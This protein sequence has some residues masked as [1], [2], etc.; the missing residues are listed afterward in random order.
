MHL[1]GYRDEEPLESTGLMIRS[2]EGVSM[3]RSQKAENI[4]RE[5]ER[6]TPYMYE[7]LYGNF[8]RNFMASDRS[9]WT[10][11]LSGYL[12][13]RNQDWSEIGGEIADILWDRF[14]RRI[15]C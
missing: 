12:S 10:N 1:K 3:N 4:V 13:T 5:M 2:G 14:E 15:S 8:L 11:D 6:V 9:R 7:G